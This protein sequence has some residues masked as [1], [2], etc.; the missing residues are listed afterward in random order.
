MAEKVTLKK[1]DGTILY[2]QTQVDTT[3]IYDGAVT[4]SKIDWASLDGTELGWKYLGE[5]KLTSA[6]SSL[7]FTL[8][9]Q[10]D[11]YK[12][13]MAAEYASG[14]YGWTDVRFIKDSTA[15]TGDFQVQD[16]TGTNWAAATNT[17]VA[18]QMN[19]NGSQYDTLNIEFTT[20]RCGTGQYRKYQ[21]E[22][23]RVGSTISTRKING[24]LNSTNDPTAF[25]L[26]T[27]H[28]FS[29]GA[30]IKVWGSNN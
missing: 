20:F 21:G 2:P 10:Y 9:A 17:N 24:R 13:V 18:Y 16:V 23:N 27:E 4:T 29:A 28:T 26:I 25:M 8:P 12:V 5:A 15:L 7:T 14:T 30:I 11:N 6:A 22:F 19:G 3:E 1:S